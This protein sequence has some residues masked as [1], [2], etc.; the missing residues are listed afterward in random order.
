MSKSQLL[1][2][3]IAPGAE[4]D[5]AV[6]STDATVFSMPSL[7][8]GES[9]D[10]GKIISTDL[11]WWGLNGAS[12]AVDGKTVPFWSTALSGADCVFTDP[13]EIIISFDS[14][15]TIAGITL[16]FSDVYCT[17][18]NIKWYQGTVLK[19]D[20]D[21]TPNAASYFCQNKVEN[22][23]KIVITM[24]ATSLP[25][26]RAR[27][28]QIIFGICRYFDMSEL[29]SVDITNEMDLLSL[30]LPA[31]KMKWVLDSHSDVEFMFQLKQPVEASNNNNLIGVYYIDTF[32]RTAGNI[33]SL[34][35]Y[36]AFGVLD[37]STFSG[38]VY[39]AKSAKALINEIVSGDFAVTFEVADTNL[40][41]ALLAQTKRAAIQQVLFAWG[42]CA[43]TDGNKGIRVFSPLATPS[44]IGKDR[45][46]AGVST[47]MA[48]VVTEVRV[49]AHTYTANTGGGVTINGTKYNDTQTVYTVTNPNVNANDKKNVVEVTGATLVSAAI[50][51]SVAQR[52]YNFYMRRVA[53]KSRFVWAGERLGDCVTQPNAWGGTNTGNIRKMEIKLSNTVAANSESAG[54]A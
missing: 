30:T 26:Q 49:T 15:Y 14:Q 34:D 54:T 24:N 52:V 35:C 31:S 6:A 18:V 48:S 9:A 7:L 20:K 40:T 46:Y 44:E 33:Y 23:N 25:R 47:E 29:R 13:P 32:T 41:G 39:N 43:S 5:A 38:G 28:R 50:G 16:V 21:F 1:Y 17:A 51:Q 22:F 2:K 53:L 3:D 11:N 27:I 10:P 36:D 8:S 45:T 19:S 37:E 12:S 4:E 42:V